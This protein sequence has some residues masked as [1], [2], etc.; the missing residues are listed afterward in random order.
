MNHLLDII[1]DKRSTTWERTSAFLTLC[2]AASLFV[3]GVVV[4]PTLMLLAGLIAL[5]V[6][7][8]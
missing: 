2:A 1:D 4:L 6:P 3:I 5:G 8:S 7:L